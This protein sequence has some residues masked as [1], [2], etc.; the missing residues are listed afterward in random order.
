[1]GIAY[2]IP[3]YVYV[4]YVGVRFSMGWSYRVNYIRVMGHVI[5]AL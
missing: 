5:P 1:M 2:A 3:W 4:I